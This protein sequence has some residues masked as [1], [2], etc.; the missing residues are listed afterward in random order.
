MKKVFLIVLCLVSFCYGG[1]ISNSCISQFKMNENDSGSTIKDSQNN[2][3]GTLYGTGTTTAS[4]HTT[5]IIDG[6]ITFN[7]TN[8]Y[9]S[10]TDLEHLAPKETAMPPLLGCFGSVWKDGDVYHFY[11]P[12]QTSWDVN[13]ATSSDGITWTDDAVNNPVMDYGS[14]D[15]WDEHINV[16]RTFKENGMWY[17]L[18]RGYNTTTGAYG[19]GLATSPDGITWTKEVTN[20]VLSYGTHGSWDDSTDTPI[21]DPWG[22][23]KVGSTYYMYYNCDDE[24]IRKTGI[25]TS[26]DLVNWTKDTANNPIFE[27]GR[28]CPD[29]FKYGGYYYIILPNGGYGHTTQ[30]EVYRDTNPTF[31]PSQREY[32]GYVLEV[33][34]SGD[35]DDY[36]LDTPSILVE[37]INKDSFPD[38]PVKLYYTGRKQS[39]LVWSQGLA[40]LDLTK[41]N[42]YAPPSGMTVCCWVKLTGTTNGTWPLVKQTATSYA[43]STFGMRILSGEINFFC[44]NGTSSTLHVITPTSTVY[45]QWGF[46]AA[47]WDNDANTL[48][49][50]ANGAAIIT[51]TKSF[52]GRPTTHPTVLLIGSPVNK[53]S[54]I[55]GS[56]DNVMVFNRALSQDEINNLYNA[57][58][59]VEII[60]ETDTTTRTTRNRLRYNR[61]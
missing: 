47:G 5:G 11:Y 29:V 59:G 60:S 13:H 32:C 26:S 4:R 19:I 44:G 16:V 50:S 39:T 36:Y 25:A 1:N 45:N 37:D 48:F 30:F 46:I 31:Y 51:T 57:G 20:P 7:G 43:T 6:A 53:S 49:S 55:N 27:G 24:G 40:Y 35:F 28:F 52:S 58:R 17:M 22:I 33:G 10:S 8:E 34:A 14:E 3:T 42:A 41:L 15:D 38:T 12:N 9:I 61:K 23:I 56:I 2:N 21:L 54:Y 18:Y